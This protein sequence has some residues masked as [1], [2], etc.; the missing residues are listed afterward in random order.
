MY[1]IFGQYY[2]NKAGREMIKKAGKTRERY[3]HKV[4]N[5]STIWNG[6]T[7]NSNMLQEEMLQPQNRWLV[8]YIKEWVISYVLLCCHLQHILFNAKSRIEKYMCS[9]TD[10]REFNIWVYIY[11]YS[12]IEH[13]KTSAIKFNYV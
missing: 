4:V 5:C 11:T 12:S 2:S 7:Q 6:K 9:V 10:L 8:N 3:M 13:K 1:D